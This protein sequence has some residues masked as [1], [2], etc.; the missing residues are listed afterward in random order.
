MP[1]RN[2]VNK[3]KNK[4]HRAHHAQQL[5][6]KR[7]ARAAT[8]LPTRSSHGRYNKNTVPRPTDSKAVALYTGEGP[9]PSSGVTTNTLSGKRAKKLERNSRYI[10][11]RNEQLSIDLQAKEDMDIEMGDGESRIPRKK[12]HEKEPTHLDK[13]KQALWA[14]IDDTDAVGMNLNVTNEGTTIGVQAF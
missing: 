6:K 7:A 14:V 1:S 4:I 9:T 13:V 12:K 8:A 3:P 10:A 5:A 2:A 11:K